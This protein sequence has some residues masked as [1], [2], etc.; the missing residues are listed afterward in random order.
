MKPIACNTVAVIFVSH[1]TDEDAAGYDAA[2]AAMAVEAARQPGYLGIDAV[3][4]ADGTGIT[5]SYWASDADAQ[6]WRDHPGHSAIRADGRARWYD[7]YRL[8]VATVTRG[9]GWTR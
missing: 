8:T 1:R 3:R 5:V 7:R 9:Y 4:G 6:R 2:A